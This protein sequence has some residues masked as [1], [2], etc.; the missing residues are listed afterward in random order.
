MFDV[1]FD[2]TVNEANGIN[3]K[4]E[5][6]DRHHECEIAIYKEKITALQEELKQARILL[7]TLPNDA[8]QMRISHELQIKVLQEKLLCVGCISIYCAHSPCP[9]IHN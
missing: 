4:L 3:K 5:R 8:A 7:N 6:R 1:L 2:V 9:G